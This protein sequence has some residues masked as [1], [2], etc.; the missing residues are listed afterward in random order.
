MTKVNQ[1]VSDSRESLVN[2]DCLEDLMQNK[3]HELFLQESNLA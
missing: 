2:S 3:Y 1:I